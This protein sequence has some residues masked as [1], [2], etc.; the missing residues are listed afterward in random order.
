MERVSIL[1]CCAGNGRKAQA[2]ML[3]IYQDLNTGLDQVVALSRDVD[4]DLG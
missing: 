4:F 3:G 2:Q 1:P